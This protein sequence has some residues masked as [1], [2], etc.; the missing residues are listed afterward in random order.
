MPNPNPTTPNRKLHTVEGG[1]AADV[2]REAERL[3]GVEHVPFVDRDWVAGPAGDVDLFAAFSRHGGRSI[4]LYEAV[5]RPAGMPVPVVLYLVPLGRAGP[6]RSPRSST[7]SGCRWPTAGSSSRGTCG[8]GRRRSP[9][10]SA[11]S[12]ARPWPVATWSATGC[13]RRPPRP[14]QPPASDPNGAAMNCATA[15]RRPDGPSLFAVNR[16]PSSAIV[17]RP[18]GP[19]GDRFTV[20][21]TADAHGPP[22]PIRMRRW[23]KDAGRSHGLTCTGVSPVTDPP[24]GD[25]P[26]TNA[27]GHWRP[28]GRGIRWADCND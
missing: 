7:R 11:R 26:Q 16:P 14:C 22:W 12:S 20:E 25:M 5:C 28:R 23:L 21:L 13:S 18:T 27:P 15:S 17:E 2:V 6:G 19:A 1:T 24:T 8:R 9:R 4:E 3:T 10:T